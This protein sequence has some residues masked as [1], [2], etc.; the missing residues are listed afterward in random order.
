MHAARNRQG[1]V[2]AH[3]CPDC[4]SLCHCGGDIDDINFGE[5]SAC[6]HYKKLECSGHNEYCSDN[7]CPC[8][9]FAE[10]RDEYDE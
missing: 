1:V 8:H 2:M 6:K 4:Y 3:D 5:S 7:T 9:D 10:G